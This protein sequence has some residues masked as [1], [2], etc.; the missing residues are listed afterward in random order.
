M[1]FCPACYLFGFAAVASDKKMMP[2]TDQ[3]VN[4]FFQLFFIYVKK[5]SAPT[6][7]KRDGAQLQRNR[8][9]TT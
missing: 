5:N 6:N 3:S 4:P 7:R 8:L 2:D 9:T 1:F